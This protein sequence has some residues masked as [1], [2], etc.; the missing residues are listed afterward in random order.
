MTTQP[1]T[2]D[3]MGRARGFTLI[4]L[5]VV[6]AIISLLISILL[7]ALGRAREISRRTVCGSNLRQFGTAFVAYAADHDGWFPAKP[8][9]SGLTRIQDLATVQDLAS[10]LEWGPNFTGIIRDIVERRHTHDPV[11][12]GGEAVGPQYLPD[13]GIMLCPSDT[14]NNRPKDNAT[15]WETGKVERFEQLPRT[16]IQEATAKKSFISY[17]YV[18]LW[19]TDD[20]GDFILMA[21]QS[22]QDDTTVGAFTKLTAEDNHGIRGINV[23]LVDTHVE[24]SSAKSGSFEDMQHV[25]QRY[26]MPIVFA[27]ARY[28]DT[29]PGANRNVEVQTIE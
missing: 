13:P 20:R 10:G 29:D 2:Q 22:N 8:H 26:W 15:L 25:A 14:M 18:A 17:I 1:L 12:E 7:P 4:E 6:I 5:L 19:R 3:P 16:I 27:R 9:P 23:L 11:A 24:W 21:D 28:P